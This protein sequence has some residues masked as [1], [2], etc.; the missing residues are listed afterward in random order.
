MS[1]IEALKLVI[2]YSEDRANTDD[3]K[4]SEIN[5]YYSALTIII[6]RCGV[7]PCDVFDHDD[8]YD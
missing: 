6:D 5:N 1:I 3:V 4:H 7:A 8:N 2:H